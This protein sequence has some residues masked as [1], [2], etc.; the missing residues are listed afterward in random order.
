MNCK[1]FF[2]QKGPIL[3]AQKDFPSGGMGEELRPTWHGGAR[4]SWS[5][6]WMCDSDRK[7]IP[8]S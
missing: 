2:M 6:L 4:D 3:I 7:N 8:L 5:D 1:P